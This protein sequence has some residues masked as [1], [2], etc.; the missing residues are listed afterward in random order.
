MISSL[1]GKSTPNPPPEPS[2]PINERK[3]PIGG[4]AKKVLS[5]TAEPTRKTATPLSWNEPQPQKSDGPFWAGVPNDSLDDDS[6]ET[7]GGGG[8]SLWDGARGGA[9]SAWDFA[10]NAISNGKPS[11]FAKPPP[12]KP[13]PPVNDAGSFWS[14]DPSYMR[15]MSE[16]AGEGPADGRFT[17]WRPSVLEPPDED[18]PTTK[19]TDLAMQHLFKTVDTEGDIDMTEAR[20]AMSMYTKAAATSARKK[21]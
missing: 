8:G 18:D 20:N 2:P 3:K 13:S 9:A 12:G 21:R 15:M 5:P 10:M 17:P 16:G 6:R 19:M 11:A 4:A 14:N 7:S 1:W